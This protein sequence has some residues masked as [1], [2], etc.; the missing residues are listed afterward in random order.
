MMSARVPRAII[1]TALVVLGMH[2]S[3][4]SCVAGMLQAAGLASAGPAVRNWD[5]A[6]G[7]FESLELVRLDETVLARSGGHWMAAPGEVRWTAEDAERRERL[8]VEPIDGRPALLK[9]PRMLLCLSFWR[10]SR[11]PFHALGVVRH[12]LAAARS[13]ATWRSLPL[14][15]GLELWLAHNRALLADREAHGIPLIDFDGSKE[16]VVDAL[17][18]ACRSFGVAADE[19]R[20]A[21]AYEERLVQHDDGGAS[22]IAGLDAALELHRRLLEHAQ[23]ARARAR[24]RTFPHASLATFERLLA[25]NDVLGAL[26]TARAALGETRAA[27]VVVPIVAALLRARA[28][29]EARALL[30]ESAASLEPAL[31]DLLLG[32]LLLAAGEARG[33]V[34]RLTAACAAPEPFFQARRLLPHA[35]RAAGRRAEARRTLADLAPHALYPHGPLSLLAE[36]SWSDGDRPAALAQMADAI[37]AAPLHRRGRMRTRRAEWLATL[38][39]RT[40]AEAEL[41]LALEEDPTY[42][43]AR[44]ELESLRATPGRA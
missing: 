38:G 10:A 14:A 34:E 3:G 11:V 35:L 7:H 6:R 40:D 29:D 16:A 2:R 21:E 9:D 1:M 12:P 44:R 26:A 8:L 5:N 37:A 15:Q 17:V 31:R 20:L 30:D 19:K 13:L 32:K 28:F 39:A 33:A 42:P 41:V 25:E 43:R 4:T 23:P 22:E 18:R 27:A 36:W 24:R